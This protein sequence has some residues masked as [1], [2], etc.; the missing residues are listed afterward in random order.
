MVEAA[1]EL[2]EE[3]RYINC[4]QL[5]TAVEPIILQDPSVNRARTFSCP[6]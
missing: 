4:E 1:S 2:R 6:N 5:T 3:K